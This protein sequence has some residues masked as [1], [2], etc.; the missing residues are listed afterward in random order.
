MLR[1][2]TLVAAA[3]LILS[4]SNAGAD[5]R[6]HRMGVLV[7]GLPDDLR[8]R[9]EQGLHERGWIVGRNLLI[10]YRYYQGRSE[11]IP[12]LATELAALGLDLIVT[13]TTDPTLA[14]H[15]AAPT[16]P[17]V[18]AGVSDPVAF[19]LVE[20]LA[21]PGGSVTGMTTF[22]P[23]G[24]AGKQLQLLKELVPQ[25]SRIAVL[26]NPKNQ[27]HQRGRAQLPEIGRQL[28]VTLVIVEASAPDQFEP[29]FEAARAHGAE[30]IEIW[31][32]PLLNSAAIVALAARYR[33]PAGYLLRQ[34]VLD[35]GLLSLG[36]DQAERWRRVVVYVDKILKGERPADLPVEQPT[37]YELVVNLKTA[38]ELGIT[39]P[40]LILAEAD[41]VI[42]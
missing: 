8:T 33:L 17:L 34:S 18:F 10:E 11:Q 7:G 27:S 30:A 13:G 25:A 9:W 38:T 40:S 39:V 22:V 41:E 24:F 35:G 3:G 4:A 36:P 26:I 37:K 28:G 15:A 29:A 6:V 1:R 31:G 14:V 23:E 2:L 20:S 19:H 5:E 42:E 12:V 21:H 16:T 32:D